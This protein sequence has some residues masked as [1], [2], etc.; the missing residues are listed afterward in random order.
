M[1]KKNKILFFLIIVSSIYSSKSH[2][3]S[4][5]NE[6]VV[7][8]GE[9]K[10]DFKTINEALDYARY[11]A[12]FY[13]KVTIHIREGEYNESIFLLDNPGVNLIGD[14]VGKTVIKSNTRYPNATICA[15]GDMYV[16]G[17]TFISTGGSDAYAFHYEIANSNVQGYTV[18]KDCEFIS[19]GEVAAIGAG[20]GENCTLELDNCRIT[21]NNGMGLYF[22]NNPYSHISNQNIVL[23]NCIIETDKNDYAIVIDDSA[24]FNGN[25]N[26]AV[27]IKINRLVTTSKKIMFRDEQGVY[28]KIPINSENFVVSEESMNNDIECLNF[29]NNK[30]GTLSC[31]TIGVIDIIGH[32]SEFMI[33]MMF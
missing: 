29:S 15:T 25:T 32:C 16:E 10:N 8:V 14:G 4:N 30:K 17:I 27:I 11:Y 26:S 18:F 12:T 21:N 23:N 28:E 20:L 3:Y 9:E 24:S 19:E 6:L 13:Y 5:E 33:K 2:A 7:C 31:V 22:H 1:K